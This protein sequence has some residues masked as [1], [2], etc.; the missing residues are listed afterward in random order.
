MYS[1][2]YDNRDKPDRYLA[3]ARMAGDFACAAAQLCDLS[4]HLPV[5]TNARSKN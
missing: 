5:R 3:G 1:K 2:R 4:G